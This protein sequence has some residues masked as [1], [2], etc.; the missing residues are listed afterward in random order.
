MGV[1]TGSRYT[2]KNITCDSLSCSQIDLLPTGF[3]DA[4]EDAS[5]TSRISVDRIPPLPS[6]CWSRVFAANASVSA[7]GCCLGRPT[8][9]GEVLTPFVI[10]AVWI[11]M[12]RYITCVRSRMESDGSQKKQ[13]QIY[14][15]EVGRRLNIL[16]RIG[17]AH[18]THAPVWRRSALLGFPSVASRARGRR[19]W[20]ALLPRGDNGTY[21]RPH[22][23]PVLHYLSSCSLS[24][25]QRSL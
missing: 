20:D 16:A 23:K 17:A 25:Q 13:R 6:T 14:L 7:V 19:R 15:I 3:A 18:V 8:R 11:D 9:G 12:P 2:H 21:L 4:L 10:D 1:D 22:L 5:S 24:W